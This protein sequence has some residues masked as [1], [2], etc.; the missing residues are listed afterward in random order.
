MIDSL[1]RF[2]KVVEAGSIS[3]ASRLLY[4][5]QPALSK[6]IKFLEEQ[7]G[8]ELLERFPTGVRPTAYGTILYTTACE[9][10][11]SLLSIE[12]QILK[13]KLLHEP[14]RLHREINI[15]CS[16]IWNDFLMPEVMQT[17]DQLDSYT[18]NIT[19]DTSEQLLNDLLEGDR[20]DFVLC[21]ILE[22]R[23]YRSLHSIPL[24]KSQPALF[25]SDHH[26]IFSTSFEKKELLKLKWIKLKT[27]PVLQQS[28][29]TPAGLSYFPEDFFPPEVSI[30]VE[31]LIAVIQLLRNNYIIL[32]PL[33]LSGLLEKYGIKPIPFPKTLTTTYWLG[34]V[35][36][37]EREIPPHTRE[38]MNSIQLYFSS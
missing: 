3:R 24:F 10:D 31:D 9:I 17:L 29:L 7:Y 4:V 5:S 18:I 21:R 23:N 38:L 30:E 13:E 14:A 1:L 36:S 34:M 26:P 12:Q 11:R 33:A 27:L 32:L 16:T 22:D 2:K 37:R 19:G 28:D 15:G 25:V 6:S 35:H 20:Y 8:V